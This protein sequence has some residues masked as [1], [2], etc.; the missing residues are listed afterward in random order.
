MVAETN[1]DL[2]LNTETIGIHIH[3][4]LVVTLPF[5]SVSCVAKAYILILLLMKLILDIISRKIGERQLVSGEILDVI[6]RIENEWLTS[7][8]WLTYRNIRFAH[9]S[10][11]ALCHN[12]DRFTE[13]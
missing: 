8:L 4:L 13:S 9:S 5:E 2:R 3:I 12:D 1:V 6:S 11:G 10:V 7:E